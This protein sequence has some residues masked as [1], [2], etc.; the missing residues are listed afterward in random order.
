MSYEENHAV[1]SVIVVVDK[2]RRTGLA[3]LFSVGY[4][5]SK[6]EDFKRIGGLNL[7]YR[8]ESVLPVS[9]IAAFSWQEGSDN[10]GNGSGSFDV[11][12]K[13][14]E[15]DIKYYSL[16]AGPAYRINS[17]ISLYAVGGFARTKATGNTQRQMN[18]NSIKRRALYGRETS[19]AYGAGIIINPRDYL[20]V[21]TGYEGTR[22]NMADDH[23]INGFNIGVGYR[24]K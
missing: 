2:W 8:Y 1:R 4:A 5:Q 15:I 6:V 21:N 7:Q 23:R 24:F 14:S 13:R 19:F 18:N 10:I 3:S 12:N 20:T 17:L 16:L 11:I 22:I 9:L